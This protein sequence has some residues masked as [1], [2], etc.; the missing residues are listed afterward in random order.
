VRTP[1]DSFVQID[2]S[3]IGYFEASKEEY[4]KREKL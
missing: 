2:H 3:N 4:L 1:A